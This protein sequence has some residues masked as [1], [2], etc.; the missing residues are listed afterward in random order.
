M[1]NLCLGNPLSQVL[2]HTR[3]RISGEQRVLRPRSDMF[4]HFLSATQHRLN[5]VPLAISCIS[6]MDKM[7]KRLSVTC[8]R[9]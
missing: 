5:R 9:R 8:G 1:C 7:V 6:M 2:Y 4:L 3:E